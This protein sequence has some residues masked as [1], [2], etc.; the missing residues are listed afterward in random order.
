MGTYKTM[1]RPYAPSGVRSYDDHDKTMMC[2]YA[3]III[4]CT[5]GSKDKLIFTFLFRVQIDS[6]HHYFTFGVIGGI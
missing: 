4:Y 3:I 6:F 5:H 1:M 2:M